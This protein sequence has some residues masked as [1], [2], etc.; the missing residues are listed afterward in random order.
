MATHICFQ[1]AVQNVQNELKYNEHRLVYFDVYF[2]YFFVMWNSLLFLT[3]SIEDIDRILFLLLLNLTLEILHFILKMD[4]HN[5]HSSTHIH[6]PLETSY[7]IYNVNKEF[8]TLHP[9]SI[10]C[11]F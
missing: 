2:L 8:F 3:I 10:I 9:I 6:P 4:K 1:T 5:V 7:I 11:K